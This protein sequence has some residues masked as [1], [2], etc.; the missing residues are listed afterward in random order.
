MRRIPR[1]MKITGGV[2]GVIAA[3]EVV[4]VVAWAAGAPTEV[5][6][7]IWLALMVTAVAVTR[8]RRWVPRIAPRSR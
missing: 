2:V 1:W 5:V 6:I 7:P 4:A 8:G 3:I